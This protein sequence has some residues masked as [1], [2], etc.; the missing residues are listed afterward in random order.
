MLAS[1]RVPDF[2][3]GGAPRCGTSFLA[4]RMRQHPQICLSAAKE[5]WYFV[6]APEPRGIPGI[7][8]IRTRG[9]NHRGPK[10]YE[11]QFA[12]CRPGQVRGE[13]SVGYLFNTESAAMIKEAVP[14][15]KLVFQLRDPVDRIV[16]QYLF[17]LRYWRL[18]PLE[19]MIA[20]NDGRLAVWIEASRYSRHLE[21]FYELFPR[22]NILVTFLEDM[23]GDPLGVLKTVFR[24]VGADPSF[25]PPDASR[26]VNETRLSRSR[27]VAQLLRSRP[28]PFPRIQERWDRMADVVIRFNTRPAELRVPPG[29]RESLWPLVRDDFEA[30]PG[31]IGGPVPI[32]SP[33]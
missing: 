8:G 28:L 3:I 33:G 6:I 1:D 30:L 29:V 26:A 27:W 20:D 23:R 4:R 5:P 14:D 11:A 12:K 10:W 13:A 17:D 15:V 16:S 32:P 7:F 19:R 25:V 9:Y 31:V 18:P 24:F 21:R 2:I 22:E